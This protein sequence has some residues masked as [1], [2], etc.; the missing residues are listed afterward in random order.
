MSHTA[1][2]EYLRLMHQRYRQAPRQG[3]TPL[4]T[5]FCRVTGYHRKYALRLL[6]GPRPATRARPGAAGPRC[7]ARG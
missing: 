6:N 4:L 7:T 2:W 5:E 1:K 3:R